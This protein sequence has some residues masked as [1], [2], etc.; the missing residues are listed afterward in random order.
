MATTTSNR[1]TKI[2]SNDEILYENFD[3]Q[4]N[5]PNPILLV[6]CLNEKEETID[7]IIAN[8]IIWCKSFTLWIP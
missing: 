7:Y 4:N 8:T 6:E 3:N 1:P 5:N 2:R